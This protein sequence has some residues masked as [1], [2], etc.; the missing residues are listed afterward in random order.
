MPELPVLIQ[1]LL[2]FFRPLTL[3]TLR[4]LLDL[5]NYFRSTVPNYSTIVAPQQ[6]LTL[7]KQTKSS[8]IKCN[9]TAIIAIDQIDTA[10]SKCCLKFFIDDITPIQL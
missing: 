4:S 1:S 5:V 2:N 10:I 6:K 3:T 9:K 8:S 7:G